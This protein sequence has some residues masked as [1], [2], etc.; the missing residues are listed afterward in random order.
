[1]FSRF[2]SFLLAILLLI[3]CFKGLWAQEINPEVYRIM[4]SNCGVKG[5]GFIQ[6]GFRAQYNGQVGIMTALHGVAGC[7]R[8]IAA[9]GKDIYL[10]DLK[11]V[12]VDLAKDVA[13]L[14]SKQLDNIPGAPIQ[15][16]N[17]NINRDQ[18][19]VVGYPDGVL[20]QISNPLSYHENPLRSLGSWHQQVKNMCE[21]RKSPSC[22]TY[23]LLVREDP[24]QPGHSGAPIFN[25]HGQVVGIA[26]GGLKGG[27]ALLNW[28]VP[29]SDVH[30]VPIGNCEYDL[31]KLKKKEV[32]ALFASPSSMDDDRFPHGHGVTISG[33]IL[34]GGYGS[35]PIGVISNYTKAYAVVQLMETENRRDIPID[36]SYNNST[37]KYIIRNV[38]SGKFTPFIRLESG[39]PFHKKSGGDFISFLSGLNEDIIVAPHDININRNLNVVHSIHLKRPVDNQ[40]ERTYTGD[41][42]EVLYRQSFYPSAAVFEWEPVPGAKRYEIRILLMDGATKQKINEKNFNTTSTTMHPNLDTNHRGSYYMFSV[43]AFK[44]NNYSDKIG[45]FTNYYKNGFGGWFIFKVLERP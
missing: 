5:K 13:F 10:T 16:T 41:P 6:T 33:Q 14:S 25:Q 7:N 38:P 20:T 44:G 39:Y 17:Y 11:L 24:L 35:P 21:Q 15:T 19:K 2:N 12:A 18:L 9:Q 8:Y 26:N 45:F 23:V 37:G 36:F 27:F 34:Y 31:R 32:T 42:P 1:M 28:I 43:T 30:L 4:L 3:F 40:K 22:N 29:Y